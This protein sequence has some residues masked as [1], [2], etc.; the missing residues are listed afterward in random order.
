MVPAAFL[1]SVAVF[2]L[3]V[4]RLPPA[5]Q[6]LWFIGP[7]VMITIAGTLSLS[8]HRSRVFFICCVLAFCLWIVGQETSDSLKTVMLF[9]AVPLNFLLVCY[10]SERGII[11]TSG[12][13][14][15]FF[16]AWQVALAVYLIEQQV[17]IDPTLLNPVDNFPTWLA[18]PVDQVTAF[19]LA[20]SLLGC[21]VFMGLDETPINQG[22][23]TALISIVI[24]YFLP[25]ENA[26][27]IFCIA[28]SAYLVG[29]L[30][31]DSYNM[32]YRD[33][34]TGLPHRR[35]LNEQFLSLGSQYSLAM[36]DVDHFKKFNDTHGHDVGDQV[37]QM[38]AAKIRQVSGGGKAFRYGGEEFSVVF[39]RMSADDAFYYLDEV[40]KSVQN[41]EMVIRKDPRQDEAEE[42]VAKKQRKRGSFRKANEKVSVTISIGVADRR[43][44]GSPDEVLKAADAALYRAK[45]A[46]RNQVTAA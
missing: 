2:A 20:L 31:R 34:L 10:F 45:K 42:K 19:V 22:M 43:S 9:A 23:T 3:N 7:T 26:W 29:S 32:A 8:Y 17:V 1:L 5:P 35:A 40:R 21:F 6:E 25:T 30:I 33:E 44:G 28:G 12:L 16:I 15:L 38:V 37:L 46:G 27:A 11:T 4:K 36:L 18:L 13:I 14:R 24:G 39:T 41:Y